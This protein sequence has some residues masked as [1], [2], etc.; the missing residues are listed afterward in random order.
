MELI[1]VGRILRPQGRE[2]E[3]R[4]EPLTDE[5]GRLAALR[6]CYLVPPEGGEPRRV[7]AFR[8]QG[9]VPV[10]KLS[11]SDGIGAAETL[12]GRLV[13]VPRAA[14]RHLPSDRFYAFDLVGCAVRDPAGND[15]GTITDV[16]AGDHHDLWVV[17]AGQREWLMPAVAAIVERVDLADRVVVARPPD[18]LVDLE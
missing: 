13:A 11:G 1:A 12:A 9:S 14:V 15:L 5:P 4:V 10:L 6:E 8:F 17:Q 18:G 3:V 2:G 16:L 7:E